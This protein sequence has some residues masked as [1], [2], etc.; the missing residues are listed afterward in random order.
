[1]A[2]QHA[3]LFAGFLF[4]VIVLTVMWPSRKPAVVLTTAPAS[5]SPGSSGGFVPADQ[6]PVSSG[7]AE[8]TYTVPSSSRTPASKPGDGAGASQ[9]SSL[10]TEDDDSPQADATPSSPEE[11][12]TPDTPATVEKR[13]VMP[14]KLF[15]AADFELPLALRMDTTDAQLDL[16]TSVPDCL[17]R[18]VMIMCFHVWVP[19]EECLADPT[20]VRA[21]VRSHSELTKEQKTFLRET[22][23]GGPSVRV[24]VGGASRT[25]K[26]W[27]LSDYLQFDVTDV[28][29]YVA[30]FGQQG[31]AAFRAEHMYEHLFP[32]QVEIAAAMSYL[33]LAP[34]GHYRVAVP[35]GY[36]PDPLYRDHVEA[37]NRHQHKQMW[38]VDNMPP[39]WIKAG[40]DVQMMENF[41]K[42]GQF[43]KHDVGDA[44]ADRE[45]WSK[46]YRVADLE[47]IADKSYGYT[48][49]YF[50]AIKPDDC[51][52]WDVSNKRLK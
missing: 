25:F 43:Y 12:D 2:R 40:F 49:L 11:D 16:I 13:D 30:A 3:V 19:I 21:L 15:K 24:N 39:I 46:V 9:A 7:R 33:F 26:G 47:K 10:A 28:G 36:H 41:D 32:A 48:S 45:K 42:H 22:R 17:K 8:A 14:A 50:D 44:E 37:G 35:E 38:T 27:V 6:Q 1:M 34:G 23:A 51:P 18:A 52:V 4:V 20:V 5:H 31:V 29:Q